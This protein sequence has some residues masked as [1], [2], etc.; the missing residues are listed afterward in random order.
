MGCSPTAAANHTGGVAVDPLALRYR[1]YPWNLHPVGAVGE[2]LPFK[3][4]SF[5][6]VL[7]LNV[8]DHTIEPGRVLDEIRRVLP[9]SGRLLFCINV[10]GVP[11]A[12]RRRLSKIDRPHPWHFCE[13]EV[14]DL[15]ADRFVIV[16][17]K[18]ERRGGE[19]RTELA[20]RLFRMRLLS[21]SCKRGD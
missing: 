10:F 4:A 12:V 16:G 2:S 1:G 3:D 14:L 11:A 17:S 21:V 18:T 13:A 5:D 19:L 20:T 9:R 15:L 8:L 6:T 7:C